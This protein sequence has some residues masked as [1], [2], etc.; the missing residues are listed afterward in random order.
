MRHAFI[1]TAYNEIWLLKKIVNFLSHPDC[2]IYINLDY[3]KALS[4]EDKDFF[5]NNKHVRFCCY[6]KLHWGGYSIIKKEI[7]LIEKVVGD[8]RVDYVHLVSGQDYPIKP[9]HYIFDFFENAGGNSFMDC[10]PATFREITRRLL[11]FIPYDYYDA[12]SEKG[13]RI[14]TFL[15]RFQEKIRFRRYI[16]NFP[17]L[18]YTGSQWCS[19]SI[20]ACKYLLDFTHENKFF[21]NLNHTFAAE[22]FY[23]PTAL[24]NCYDRKKVVT[25]NNLRFI[26]WNA[27]NGNNPSNLGMEHFKMLAASKSLFA[28]KMTGEVSK[29]LVDSIDKFLLENYDENNKFFNF[30]M[31][32]AKGIVWM[33]NL[34][35]IHSV[36]HVGDNLLY[37]SALLENKFE[38]TNVYLTSSAE[39]IANKLGITEAVSVADYCSLDLKKAKVVF[40]VLLLVN[41]IERISLNEISILSR[42]IDKILI[43]ETHLNEKKKE[44][45]LEMVSIG[46]FHMEKIL[47]K[48]LTSVINLKEIKVYLL[49]K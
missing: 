27:E 30:E 28:R 41:Q 42:N 40:D 34:Q 3:G 39:E 7:Q 24:G 22:E 19:L 36:L 33:F 18:I 6:D 44:K 21:K 45:V 11:A 16:R 49:I 46:N 14:T 31:S 13:H 43:V 48:V 38:T 12:R 4:S 5:I 2:D 17:E 37:T 23:I 10:R 32:I 47:N 26:R 9:L 20:E 25:N 1:I 29:E 8:S 15:R 35:N